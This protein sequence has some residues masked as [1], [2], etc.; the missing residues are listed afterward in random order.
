MSALPVIRPE[1]LA[2]ALLL[3]RRLRAHDATKGEGWK[4]KG[5]VDHL[6]GCQASALHL[7][8]QNAPERNAQLALDAA[9]RAMFLLDVTGF[10]EVER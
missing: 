4:R 3:E 6:I 10:L 8:V 5:A 2:F 1:L 7:K 9:N